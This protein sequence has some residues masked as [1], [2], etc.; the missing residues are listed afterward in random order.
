[1]CF[2]HIGILHTYIKLMLQHKFIGRHKTHSQN[3]ILVYHHYNNNFNIMFE[4]SNGRRKI[5]KHAYEYQWQ[6][7]YYNI[8]LL[9][10]HVLCKILFTI[11]NV[12][13]NIY[14]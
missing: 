1:M 4:H 5:I 12:Y 2:V 7:G 11:M 10:K 3:Q 9:Y 8:S 13:L 6:M 14:V